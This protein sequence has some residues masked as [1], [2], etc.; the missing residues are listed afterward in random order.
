MDHSPKRVWAGC[1]LLALTG[2]MLLY[3]SES[4]QAAR[5]GLRLCADLL[6]PALFPFLALSSLLVSTGTLQDLARP[7]RGLTGS[8]LGTG[9]SGGAVL[10]LGLAGG[11]PVGLRTLSQLTA[12]GDCTEAE[13][14]RLSLFCNNCGPAFFLSAAGVGVF[15]AKRI[16]FLLMGTNALAALCIAVFLRLSSGKTS[17]GESSLSGRAS[18]KTLGEV[19]PD[20]VAASF[21]GT[22]QLCGYVTLFMVLSSLVERAGFLSLWQ[23]VLHKLFPG[24]YEETLAKS[25]LVGLLEVSTGLVSLTDAPDLSAAL[26][27]ASF[28][29]SWGGLSVHAQSLPFLRS[30]HM[31]AAPYLIA[32]FFQGILS[33]ALTRLALLCFPSALPV[34]ATPSCLVYP[35][36]PGREFLALWSVSGLCFFLQQRKKS[37]KKRRNAI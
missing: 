9:S 28:L 16:G 8:I 30:V 15:H 18:S 2:L 11:Y 17:S 1:V 37:G 32:K 3:P 14:H 27:L 21:S 35:S 6:I 22:L 25:L 20:C 10:L 12:R 7:L 26:P 19:F 13:A 31:P 23:A 36:L 24:W 34:M 33:A 29:L 4:S 5:E